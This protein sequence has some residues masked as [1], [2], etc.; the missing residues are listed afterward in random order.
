M[1]KS[2]HVGQEYN[3]W[4][5]LET[6][7]PIVTSITFYQKDPTNI[8]AVINSVYFSFA[9]IFLKNWVFFAG[10]L[11]WSRCLTSLDNAQYGL[12]FP[13]GCATTTAVLQLLK[14]GDHILSC[15]ETYG[16]TRTIFTTQVENQGIEV[17]FVDSTDVELFVSAIKPNTRVKLFIDF[18]FREIEM[19]YLNYSSFGWKRRRIH[20]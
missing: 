1:T 17:D 7:A 18:H 13:S 14:T 2:I 20:V 8:F 10:I 3:Q 6:V 12:I 9:K 19:F 5:N 16:G 15:S 11:L 4:S